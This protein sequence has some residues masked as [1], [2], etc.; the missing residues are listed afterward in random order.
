MSNNKYFNYEKLGHFEK[1][2]IVFSIKKKIK[3]DK[4]NNSY[5]QWNNKVKQ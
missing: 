3:S 5:Q 1:N 4:F 2:C